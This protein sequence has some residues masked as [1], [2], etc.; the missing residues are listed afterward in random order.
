MSRIKRFNF[1]I[2]L[3]LTLMIL[4]GGNLFA[5]QRN[6][7]DQPKIPDETQINKMVEELSVKLSLNETQKTKILTL[8]V[9]HFAEIK[10][11][12]SSGKRPSR[13]EM[14]SIRENFQDAVKSQL[15]SEQQDL[16]DDFI[17]KNEKQPKGEQKERR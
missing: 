9:D 1:G 3:L 12:M 15:N 4:L 2:I 13:E 8:Y 7:Q 5:Q 14:E 6:G 16:Y 11:S 17:K 10:S